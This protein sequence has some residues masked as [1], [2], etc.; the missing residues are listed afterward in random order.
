MAENIVSLQG[1]YLTFFTGA[2][3]EVRAAGPDM[4]QLQK[5]GKW[6]AATTVEAQMFLNS[7]LWAFQFYS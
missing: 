3:S 2:L 1:M 4:L 7:S 5:A 6:R